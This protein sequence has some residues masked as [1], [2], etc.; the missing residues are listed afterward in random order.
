M[1]LSSPLVNHDFHRDLDHLTADGSHRF[2]EWAL[3]HELAFL[4]QPSGERP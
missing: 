3:D 1:T 2:A 4:L